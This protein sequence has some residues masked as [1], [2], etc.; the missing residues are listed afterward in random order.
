MG[1]CLFVFFWRLFFVKILSNGTTHA[2]SPKS[3]IFS[4][5]NAPFHK[6]IQ[7]MD[8]KKTKQFKVKKK[9]FPTRRYLILGTF[10][11]LKNSDRTLTIG[12]S[13]FYKKSE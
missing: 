3:N 12:R 11:I 1:T 5:Q 4:K 10:K 7:N 13:Q 9:T 2:M 8:T 6:K